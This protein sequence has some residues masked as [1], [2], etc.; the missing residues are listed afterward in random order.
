MAA[1]LA[2]ARAEGR[3][4]PA[5]GARC[6]IDPGAQL[7]RTAVWDDVAI[8]DGC[9]LRDC[10]VTDGVHVPAGSVFERQIITAGGGD[11]YVAPLPAAQRPPADT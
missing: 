6:R 8:A 5:P 3:T 4:A 7:S 2:V 1:A 11:M 10:I 9:R